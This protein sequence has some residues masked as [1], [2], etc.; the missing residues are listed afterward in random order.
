[1]PSRPYSRLL[2]CAQLRFSLHRLVCKHG[3]NR[4]AVRPVPAEHQARQAPAHRPAEQAAEGALHRDVLAGAH[5]ASKR[6][7]A[8]RARGRRRRGQPWCRCGRVRCARGEPRRGTHSPH[9]HRDG[10]KRATSAP[11]LGPPVPHL[12]RDSARPCH[13]CTGTCAGLKVYC[14]YTLPDW[15][16]PTAGFE[17]EDVPK[18]AAAVHAWA[19]GSVTL[20]VPAHP[21][22]TTGRSGGTETRDAP[23]VPQRPSTCPEGT[24]RR[25]ASFGRHRGPAYG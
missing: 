21:M 7:A 17:Y 19:F 9:L 3:P 11:G 25:S 22:G 12:H 15:A 10:L 24:G 8:P 16:N 18:R 2:H 14:A 5:R 4:A 6:T 23:T 13:I 1:V 20:Q